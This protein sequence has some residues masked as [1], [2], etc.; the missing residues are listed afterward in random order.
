[1]ATR[2][3]R[4]V[5]TRPLLIL[6]F[7][8]AA[9][10]QARAGDCAALVFDG[11]DYTVC[12]FDVRSDEIRLVWRG[13]NAAPYANFSA[14]A[15]SLRSKGRGLRFAMNGGMYRE[16]LSPLGLYV[17]DSLTLHRADARDG[18]TN[19]HLKPNGVF[20]I[21]DKSAGVMETS[22]YL[23]NP[24]PAKFATQSGPMLVVDGRIHPKIH[25]TGLSAKLR[26][27]VCVRDGVYAMFAI[28][29]EPV[30]FHAFAR[31]FKDRLNCANALFLDGSVSSLYSPELGRDDE[32]AP[33]GPMIAVIRPGA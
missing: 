19:F 32:W 4:E 31:L 21:G 25:P 18:A 14:L 5:F 9:L 27:G 16:D 11:D 29:D 2:R 12:A 13:P 22:R 17:E 7:W 23:A 1:M 6:A 3:F 33:L 20:W 26:N 24:P 10:A 30:T 28:S 15:A 8:L